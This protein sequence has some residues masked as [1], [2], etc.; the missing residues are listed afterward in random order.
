M[1]KRALLLLAALWAIASPA[2]AVPGAWTTYGGQCSTIA[3]IV[4]FSSGTT[5]TIPSDYCAF[6]AVMLIGEGG[7]ASGST[8]GGGGAYAYKGGLNYSPSQV[9]NIQIGPGGTFTPT[10]WDSCSIAKADDGGTPL[11]GLAAN[12][13]GDVVYSGGAGASA[14]GGGGAAGPFGAGGAG[15]TTTGGT[16]DNG[17]GGV[18]GG[19]GNGGGSGGEIPL[20]SGGFVGTGGGGGKCGGTGNPNPGG[21]F[22]GGAGGHLTGSCFGSGGP[23]VI[24]LRYY[25]TI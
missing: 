17:S 1:I 6:Q 5:A 13:I 7:P 23:G 3:K 2:H 10:C 24:V 15:S 9:V 20:T 18:G 8:P 19:P 4:A 14:G 11:A 16:G 12:S 22:G 25:P 21:S